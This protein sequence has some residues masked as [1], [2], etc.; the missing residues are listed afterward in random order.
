M[1][2]LAASPKRSGALFK[3]PR[4]RHERESQV[5]CIARVLRSDL[6]RVKVTPAK[7]FLHVLSGSGELRTYREKLFASP[8]DQSITQILDNIWD[9]PKGHLLIKDWMKERAVDLVCDTI[10]HEMERAKPHSRM[11]PNEATVEFID[12][13]DVEM[14]MKAVCEDITPT[15]SRVLHEATESREAQRKEKERGRYI[16][17][18]QA[19]YLRSKFSSKFQIGYG[20]S[21]WANGAPKQ[22]IQ[23]LHRSCLGV[24]YTAISSISTTLAESELEAARIAADKA[25]GLSY[26][27]INVSSSIFVEQGPNAMSKVQSGTFAVIYE[28][29]NANKDDMKLAPIL[30][31]L[32]SAPPLEMTDLQPS[33]DA[34]ASYVKQS[35]ITIAKILI[36]HIKGFEDYHTDPLLQHSIRRRL[37]LRHKTKYHPLRASTI[38]EASVEGNLSLTCQ[39]CRGCQ[40]ER[41]QDVTAFNRREIFQIAFGVFHLIMNLLWA[42]LH[43]HRGTIR[44]TG[45]LSHLFAILEKTRLGGEKPDYHTLLSAM[46]QIVR[47]LILNAWRMECGHSSLSEFAKSCP[48]TEEIL[49]IATKIFNTYTVPNPEDSPHFDPSD[50]IYNNTILLIRD[51]MYVMEL[52]NAT[53]AGDWGSIEDILPTLACMFR[54]ARSKNY[55]SE[56]LYLLHNL[57]SVW[58]PEF[59]YG[60]LFSPYPSLTV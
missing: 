25:H 24:S 35:V 56:I 33:P 22:L 27:N 3:Q 4:Q 17:S 32:K 8:N 20:L 29:L 6:H 45:S 2:R 55:A 50:M 15:F 42:L 51:L 54:G 23:A 11:Q 53:A 36:E 1:P 57:K 37:S 10:A 59:A 18:A 60:F 40:E 47:G 31:R 7:F 28:L 49:N 44:Q 39:R 12:N 43:I 9:D 19:H 26:D 52:V 5:E 16:L 30:E 48:T 21:A 38:E 14:I 41:R 13:W 34:M 46:T 58:T